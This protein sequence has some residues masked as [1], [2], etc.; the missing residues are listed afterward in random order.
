VQTL[1]HYDGGARDAAL[2]VAGVSRS[3]GAVQALRTVSLTLHAGEI[4][5]LLGPNGAGKTT[6]IRICAGWLEAERGGVQINGVRQTGSA[7]APRTALGMVS[8]DAP[9][10]DDLTVAETVRLHAGLHG[11]AGAAAR[12][13][14][15]QALDAYRLRDSA[16]RRIGVLS[17]GMR[18]RVALAAALVH[19]PRVLLLDEP[20]A[21]LDPDVRQHIW[22]YLRSAAARGVAM[23]LTT[24]YFDEAARLCDR[25][26][27]L[28][29][30]VLGAP[31]TPRTDALAAQELERA[32]MD[33]LK[34]E[35]AAP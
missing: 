27:L 3:F 13:A 1:E 21:G 16:A 22:G 8:R 4:V 23:L 32:F 24:H 9:L 26:H 35:H 33:A 5:G 15:G 10:Y 12:A 18:Q 29:D 6:L 20:T 34:W 17:T 7:L 2:V 11:M 28:V 25:V 30:G 31:L 19:D 14:C